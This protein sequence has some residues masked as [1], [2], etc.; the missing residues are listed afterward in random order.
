MAM[1]P[2]AIGDEYLV[3]TEWKKDTGELRQ[4]APAPMPKPEDIDRGRGFAKGRR[5]SASK[6]AEQVSKQQVRQVGSSWLNWARKFEMGMNGIKFNKKRNRSRR[7]T[8]ENGGCFMRKPNSQSA[9]HASFTH[10]R[11]GHWRNQTESF[12]HA[13]NDVYI[14]QIRL[15]YQ[16]SSHARLSK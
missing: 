13:E 11:G 10:G 14:N 4:K 3:C 8:P 9:T 2:N 7:T 12:S 16:F 1:Q 6:V 15:R 5:R